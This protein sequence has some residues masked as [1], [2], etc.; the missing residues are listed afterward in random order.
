MTGF[1]GEIID[2]DFIAD[3]I[4]QKP[5]FVMV[6]KLLHFEENKITAG[7]TVS[8]DNIFVHHSHFAAAGLIE[9]MAQTVALYTGYRFFL[10]KEKA[11]I[12]YIGAIKK[13]EVLK[14]PQT[15]ADLIT[16]VNV[17]HDI[18]DVTLVRA[19]TKCGG[20]EIA[21]SEMKTILAKQ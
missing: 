6:D 8:E 5:P 12:G 7:L 16:T 2:A 3:L 19:S 20:R 4:P 15:G 13:A 9:H 11:P 17:L 14:L 21:S 18:M 1:N 10:K